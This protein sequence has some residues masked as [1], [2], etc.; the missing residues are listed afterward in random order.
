MKVVIQVQSAL[1]ALFAP[2]SETS[3][4]VTVRKAIE[5]TVEASVAVLAVFVWLAA[6]TLLP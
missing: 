4:Q 5:D 1:L 6:M 2:T 3:A